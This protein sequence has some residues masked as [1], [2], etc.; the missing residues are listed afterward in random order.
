MSAVLKVA[1]HPILI[2]RLNFRRPLTSWDM[3]L[4]LRGVWIKW[5]GNS[6]MVERWNGE[7]VGLFFSSVCLSTNYC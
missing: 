2:L 1:N 3:I 4:N 7:I 5:N 6:G